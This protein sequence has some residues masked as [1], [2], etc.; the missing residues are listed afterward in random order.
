MQA[1]VLAAALLVYYNAKFSMQM[2]QKRKRTY[3]LGRVSGSEGGLVGQAQVPK[4]LL[5][6]HLGVG[7]RWGNRD[8][9]LMDV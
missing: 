1:G 5:R 8:M 9:M 4:A 6:G 3:Q 2:K 7:Q